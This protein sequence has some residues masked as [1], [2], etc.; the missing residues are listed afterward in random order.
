P[1]RVGCRRGEGPAM[2]NG[3]AAH[4]REAPQGPAHRWWVLA[5]VECG[6]FVVNMDGYI[7]TMALPA[8][9]RHFGVGIHEIKWVLVAYLA[10]LTVTLLVAGRLAGLWGRKTGPVVGVALLALGAGLCALAPTL[11][12]LIAFRVVQGQG[13]A[14]VLA[15][16][17]A[18]I[19]ADFPHEQ[20]RR[21]MAVNTTVLAFG[22]VTGLALGGLLI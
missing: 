13:G 14:L 9:A 19:T 7:V 10:A 5:A 12:A 1:A 18:E 8:M 2:T 20:R 21:A 11:P 17:M 15:S 6:N 22:Q 3:L 4:L 16:V